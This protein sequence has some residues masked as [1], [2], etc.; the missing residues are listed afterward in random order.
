VT[1]PLPIFNDADASKQ[2]PGLE[3]LQPVRSLHSPAAWVYRECDRLKPGLRTIGVH[4]VLYAILRFIFNDHQRLDS[5]HTGAG[6]VGFLG[7][8]LFRLPQA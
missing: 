2:L 7:R 1:L 8:W 6:H 3:S 4:A 5:S